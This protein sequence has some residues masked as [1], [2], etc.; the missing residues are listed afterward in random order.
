MYIVLCAVQGVMIM[1][2]S[3]APDMEGAVHNKGFY[4]GLLVEGARQWAACSNDGEAASG[5]GK[6]YC[7]YVPLMGCI[8]TLACSRVRCMCFGCMCCNVQVVDAIQ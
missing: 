8:C 7:K 6:A 1:A 4:Q 2:S 3:S 5:D